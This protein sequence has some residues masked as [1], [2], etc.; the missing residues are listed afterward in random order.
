[1]TIDELQNSD[2]NLKLL[3]AQRQLYL[4]AKRIQHLREA[5][6]VGLAAIAPLIYYLIPSSR[7]TLAIIGA[8]WLLVS[9][10]LLESLEKGKVKQAAT[11]Q[12]QFDIGLFRLPWNH[13]LVGS[14]ISPELINSAASSDKGDKQKLRD[15]YPNTENI[16]YPANV[17]L[18][19]RASLVWDWRLRRVYAWG[20]I[21]L[22]ILIFLCGVMVAVA[23]NSTLLSYLLALL[24]PSL[25][26]L[27]S[28]IEIA[29]TQF[30][31]A[32]E[33][34]ELEKVVSTAWN[35]GLKDPG[36]V[37]L[38]LCR[39][40]QDSIYGLRNKRHLVP[41]KLYTWLQDKYEI[42]MRSAVE[43]ITVEA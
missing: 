22:T 10:L 6:T 16:P 11:I 3:A 38:D 4:Q 35:N 1:M 31:I 29:K 40:I 2:A 24:F 7:S 9:R 25:A 12:E 32:E 42:D 13:V 15:W 41:E 17:L 21:F 20:V 19:Q 33:K 18:C 23:T 36:T 43:E 5:G 27:L 37:S 26:A 8:S 34:F 28:G 30:S 14:R 39:D